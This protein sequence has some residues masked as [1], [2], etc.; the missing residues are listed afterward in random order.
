MNV[1][2]VSRGLLLLCCF[3]VLCGCVPTREIQ[4][5]E[6]KEPHF[7]A[8]KNRVNAMDYEGAA[9]SFEK[10]LQANPK[11]AAAHFELGWLCEQKQSDPA[12]AIYHFQQYLKLRPRTDRYADLVK[13]HIQACK[14][15]LARTI[16]LGPLTEKQQRDF[17]T[18]AAENKR[19][20]EENRVLK[21]EVM[22][23]R[24]LFAARGAPTN[25][26]SV[27]PASNV[28][29]RVGPGTASGSGDAGLAAQTNRG[30]SGNPQPR[31]ASTGMP[32]RRS[33]T[34]KPGETLA[35]IARQYGLKLDALQAAN[36][37]LD[38]RKVRAGRTI[39]IP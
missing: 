16:S 11:S 38:P 13:Q 5:D 15:E 1:R 30:S 9:E 10:A 6:E 24:I 3:V 27:L 33:H 29:A 8:G 36:P 32:A 7:L 22:K 12:A 21:E 34:V 23:W 31:T 18:M 26:L 19:L 35:S 20:Q 2:G 39:N 14:Q 37:G 28:T 17:E 25:Q 4:S